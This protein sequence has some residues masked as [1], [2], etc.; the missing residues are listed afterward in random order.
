MN[1]DQSAANAAPAKASYTAGDATAGISFR[2][3]NN[4]AAGVLFDYN[5]TDAKTDGNG[6]KT[7]VDSYSPGIYATYFNKGF[8]VN[9]LFSFG[10]NTYSN[11]RAIP[12]LGAT[13]QSSP[14]GQQYV[15]NLDG[16]YDFQPK[17]HP[18]WIFGPTLGLTYTHLNIDSFTET[19][20]S[21]ADLSV[22]S[23]SIDSL[24]SRLGAHVIYQARSG[25]I[26]F[27]PNFTAMWQHEFLD[28][29]GITS[30]LNIPGT[31][32]FTIQPAGGDK[33]SALLGCGVTMTLDNSMAF[34]VNYIADVGTDDFLAQSI[35]GGFKASF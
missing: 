11:T 9:G 14:T 16:G 28:N 7:D 4:L 21:A 12:F 27:Q 10:Y 18:E 17:R 15:T 30:Q 3:T 23:Q 35:V 1:Q 5:H 32:P 13:A 29:P 34:Y 24:R 22:A 26:L 20:A 33:D 31:S 25:S 2:M 19:G 6:S 8:Y